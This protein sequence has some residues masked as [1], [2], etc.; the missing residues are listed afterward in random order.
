MKKQIQHKAPLGAMVL[1]LASGVT[2]TTGCEPA[3]GTPQAVKTTQDTLLTP[4]LQFWRNSKYHEWPSQEV[5][6]FDYTSKTNSANVIRISEDLAVGMHMDMTYAVNH[7]AKFTRRW[8]F[9]GMDRSMTLGEKKHARAITVTKRS[10]AEDGV[11]AGQVTHADVAPFIGTAAGEDL[12]F[13]PSNSPMPRRLPAGTLDKNPDCPARGPGRVVGAMEVEV[14]D[15][16]TLGVLEDIYGGNYNELSYNG[17]VHSVTVLFFDPSFADAGGDCGLSRVPSGVLGDSFGGEYGQSIQRNVSWIIGPARSGKEVQQDKTLSYGS[18]AKSVTKETLFLFGSYP[19]HTDWNHSWLF[20]RD[21]RSSWEV[22]GIGYPR[23]SSNDPDIRNFGTDGV[24]ALKSG[25]YPFFPWREAVTQASECTDP[26]LLTPIWNY[27][28]GRY[29]TIAGED[30]EGAL[31]ILE[32]N[33]D[34]QRG[35]AWNYC[36]F[37]EDAPRAD[38]FDGITAPPPGSTDAEAYFTKWSEFEL[39]LYKKSKGQNG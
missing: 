39:S 18:I 21:R 1:T 15:P 10:V 7:P 16:G 13:T 31:A 34:R 35:L 19:H 24:V 38:A 37:M 33:E 20:N 36:M 29:E 11:L 9:K 8:A 5:K 3:Q 25:A 27:L 17:G 30:A 22:V 14:N 23:F 4:V 26:K 32:N 6:Q 28:K 2:A 12:F